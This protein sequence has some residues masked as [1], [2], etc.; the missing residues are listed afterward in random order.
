LTASDIAW[1]EG[2]VYVKG[3]LPDIEAHRIS[4]LRLEFVSAS[5]K[6][7]VIG[8]KQ[9]VEFLDSRSDRWRGINGEVL[10]MLEEENGKTMIFMGIA[11]PKHTIQMR[12]LED[13]G[14]SILPAVVSQFEGKT[15]N[16]TEDI[17]YT[18]PVGESELF[19]FFDSDAVHYG[20]LVL[21]AEGEQ[22]K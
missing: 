16:T 21:I 4:A 11:T 22:Q 7:Q 2:K 15:G 9:T 20:S 5:G 17:G 3:L 19:K 6:R 1:A 14:P 10:I 13:L 8:G 12:M 18:V